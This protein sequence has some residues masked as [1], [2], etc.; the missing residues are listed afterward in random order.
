M[1]QEN[2]RTRFSF[3]WQTIILILL[4]G[5]ILYAG[6]YY[7]SEIVPAPKVGIVR[8]EYDI[9]SFSTYIVTEQLAYARESDD[10]DA[11]VLV[12]NSPGGSASYSEELYLDVLNTRDTLPVLASIDLVAAS[13]A[14]YMA[15]GA[16]EIYAKPTSFVGSVGVIASF[17]GPVFIDDSIL[18]TGPYKLFGG[19]ETGT[20]RQ[21]EM[22]KYTFLD[23]V[24]VGRGDRLIISTDELSRAEVYSGIQAQRHGMIDGLKSTDEVVQLAAQYAG[25]NN[26]EV[27]DLFDLTF[28]VEDGGENGATLFARYQEGPIDA[29]RL[30]AFPTDLP[31]GLYY[32]HY[33][34]FSN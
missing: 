13:G 5:G 25:L 34:S 28:P 23:A 20:V 19:T 21:V 29:N 15:V 22:A 27:V 11:V 26:Y 7:A 1:S 32:R 9:S 31:P 33:E 24:A 17:G 16:Q 30:W 4:S 2:I 10:I 3:P 14:Y 8:L 6:F 18:T 12:I